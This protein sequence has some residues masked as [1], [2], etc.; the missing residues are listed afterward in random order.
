M[1]EVEEV[2]VIG[3]GVGWGRCLRIRVNLDITKPL[4]RGR[5]LSINGKPVWVNFKYEKLTQFCYYCE[6]I[7]HTQQQCKDKQ[8]F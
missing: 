6:R 1:G 4:D 8:N 5:A 3:D 2:D 7:L